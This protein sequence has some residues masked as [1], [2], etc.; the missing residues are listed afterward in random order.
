VYEVRLQLPHSIMEARS[1][2]RRMRVS[3]G[4]VIA[5][6]EPAHYEAIER[7]LD[8]FGVRD[9]LKRFHRPQHDVER[10]TVVPLDHTGSELTVH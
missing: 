7:Q 10:E 8:T 6:Y 1:L 9:T 5:H 3:L 2:L 4:R